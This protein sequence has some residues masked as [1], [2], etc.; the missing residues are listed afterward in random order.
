[1]KYYPINLD[2]RDKKSLLVGGGEVALR[3]VKCL[4]KSGSKVKI[5]SPELT[6]SF[7]EFINSREYFE[8]RDSFN[9]QKYSG[10]LQYFKRRFTEDDLEDI[11]LV[12]A[13]TNNEEVNK[14][15]VRIA[16]K[17]GVM[18]S[19]VD[20]KE[21]SD[22]TL[23]A[24]IDR[25]DFLL[26]FCTCGNLPALSKR[27]REEFEE[28]FGREYAFFLDM[29]C[30]LRSE[31]IDKVDDEDK[32]SKIFNNLADRKLIAKFGEDTAA[33]FSEIEN[34]ISEEVAIE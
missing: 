21:I 7:R 16:N 17:N 34:I 29:M 27:L 14:R 26:S 6:K 19:A 11:C 3:K 15:I 1:M 22:F 25:G 12:I 32:R 8:S 33:A 23:P 5:V 30:E 31:I 18:V 2:I 24:V 10:N 4:L 20:N 28:E 9:R 13:A